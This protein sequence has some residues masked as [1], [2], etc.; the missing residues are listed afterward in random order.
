VW[1]FRTIPGDVGAVHNNVV[2]DIGATANPVLLFLAVTG[3]YVF[4]GG[5]PKPIGTGLIDSIV[6]TLNFSRASE[7]TSYHDVSNF[8]IKFGLMSSSAS[9]FP[10]IWLVY[11]YKVDKWGRFSPGSGLVHLF[12]FTRGALTWTEFSALFPTW[13]NISPQGLQWGASLFLPSEYVQLGVLFEDGVYKLKSLTGIAASFSIAFNLI[14]DWFD[15]TTINR[16]RL[17]SHNEQGVSNL[18]LNHSYVEKIENT[19]VVTLQSIVARN[20]ALSFDFMLS[21]NWHKFTV[22]GNGF[23]EFTGYTLNGG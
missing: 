17:E 7:F 1:A 20:Q 2:V 12:D 3:F 22:S 14:G 15:A 6:R 23:L 21:T 13:N 16:F 5:L 19:D 9:D 4:E 8:S 10:D 11:N 18:L